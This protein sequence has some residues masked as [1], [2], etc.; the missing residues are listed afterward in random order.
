MNEIDIE[1]YLP[2]I[3]HLNTLDHPLY[4]CRICILSLNINVVR[5]PPT[6]PP[7]RVMLGIPLCQLVVRN[8]H[9]L[10][11]GSTPI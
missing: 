1:N 8:L 4:A 11:R 2:L 10:M 7:S 3:H 5:Y 9:Q 6:H